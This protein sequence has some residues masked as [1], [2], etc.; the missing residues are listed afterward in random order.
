MTT[1]TTPDVPLSAPAALLAEVTAWQALV[2]A[3]PPVA[4]RVD[5]ELERPRRVDDRRQPRP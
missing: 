3:S 4:D 5:D 1:T 2:A